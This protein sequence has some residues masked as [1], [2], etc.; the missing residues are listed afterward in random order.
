MLDPTTHRVYI[1]AAE[2]GPTP[3]ESTATNPRRRPVILPGSFYVM[4]IERAARP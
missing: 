3:A 2:F 4:V 1:V